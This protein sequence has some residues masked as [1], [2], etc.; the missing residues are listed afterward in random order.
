MSAMAD[1]NDTALQDYLIGILAADGPKAASRRLALRDAWHQRS[2]STT[3]SV[4][5]FPS[6]PSAAERNGE[7]EQLAALADRLPTPVDADILQSL[8]HSVWIDVRD[9]AHRLDAVR[10]QRQA[11]LKS[12]PPELDAQL[13]EL[14]LRILSSPVTRTAELREQFRRELDSSKGSRRAFRRFADR[15]RRDFADLAAYDPELLTELSQRARPAN[16]AQTTATT[17]NRNAQRTEWSLGTAA[18]IFCGVLGGIIGG[19]T[20][21]KHKPSP[22]LYQPRLDPSVANRAFQDILRRYESK[23]ERS[24]TEG[25]LGENALIATRILMGLDPGDLL[26][27]DAPADALRPANGPP[28]GDAP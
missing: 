22:Q 25:P 4:P 13:R 10:Q 8:K 7:W 11:I 6:A 26:A 21:S 18:L 15:F 23:F 2:S 16:A 12:W 28:T 9:A 19:V 24:N 5:P 14:F 20:S 17:V 3:A 27:D 1:A